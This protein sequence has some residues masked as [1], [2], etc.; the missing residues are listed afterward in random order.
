M[1]EAIRNRRSIRKYKSEPVRKA[2]IDQILQVEILASSF[3][4]RQPWKFIVATGSAKDEACRVMEDGISRERF[5]PL[6]ACVFSPSG[7]LTI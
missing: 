3:K 7:K 2:L 5:A 1:I 4:N 6:S